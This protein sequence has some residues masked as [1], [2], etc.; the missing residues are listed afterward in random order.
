VTVV[1]QAAAISA[2]GWITVSG[3]WVHTTRTGNNSGRGFS[4]PQRPPRSIEKYLGSGMI[5]GI[6]P[7]YAKS[8]ACPVSR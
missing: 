5:R 6:G 7:A 4:R 2:G 1:G 8:R 3:E